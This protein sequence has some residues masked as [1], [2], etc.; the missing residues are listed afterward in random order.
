MNT[1]G[2]L[3]QLLLMGE[4]TEEEYKERKD[5]YVEMVLEMYVKGIITKEQMLEKI[6]H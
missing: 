6:N 1:L 3:E 4:I 2:I 5:V